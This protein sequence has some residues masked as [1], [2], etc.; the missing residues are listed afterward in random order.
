MFIKAWGEIAWT[1]NPVLSAGQWY[2]VVY[3]RDGLGETSKF[4]VNGS[5]VAVTL[6]G[7]NFSDATGPTYIGTD[8]TH[9]NFKGGID[10]VR[11]S[12]IARSPA[13]IATEYEN[14]RAPSSFCRVYATEKAY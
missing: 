2:H 7:V 11:M 12:D 9:Y 6:S 3:I 13:W 1:T 4:Y 8:P 14:Q 5:P 10:E